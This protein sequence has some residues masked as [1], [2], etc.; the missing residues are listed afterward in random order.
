[1]SHIELSV[2]VVHQ[3]VPQKDDVLDGPLD[4]ITLQIRLSMDRFDMAVSAH[5]RVEAS[6]LI[7]HYE[8]LICCVAVETWY[9]GSHKWDT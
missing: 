1:M 4:K 3:F 6:Q 5:E 9:I 8:Q 7:E 2:Y